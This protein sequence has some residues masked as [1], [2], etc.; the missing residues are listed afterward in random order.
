MLEFSMLNILWELTPSKIALFM[1][2]FCHFLWLSS[3][4]VC[5]DISSILG[6]FKINTWKAKPMISD[7]VNFA[8]V[9]SFSY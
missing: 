2:V 6:F 3:A 7:A 4:S 8:P 5:V 1:C 9:S